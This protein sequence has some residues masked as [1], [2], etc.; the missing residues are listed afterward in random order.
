MRFGARDLIYTYDIYQEIINKVKL[1]YPNT[2]QRELE[3]VKDSLWLVL[4]G[5]LGHN[6]ERSESEFIPNVGKTQ[7][8]FEEEL[9]KCHTEKGFDKTIVPATPEACLMRIADKIS[10][11][12]SDL[13]DGLKEGFITGLNEEYRKELEKIGITPKEIEQYLKVKNYDSLGKRIRDIFTKDLIK[14]STKKRIAMSEEVGKVMHNLRR[15]NNRQIVDYVLMKEDF[16]IYIGAVNTLIDTY[17]DIVLEGETEGKYDN[18]PYLPF[19]NYVSSISKSDYEFTQKL[20]ERAIKQSNLEEKQVDK[21]EK[22]AI[23][24]GAK[25]LATLSDSEFSELIENAGLA[26][27]AQAQRLHIKYKDID[28]RQEAGLDSNW[29]QISKEQDKDLGEEK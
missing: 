27:K 15:I 14:N 21:K 25:Y 16:P 22:M 2:S 18:T 19:V 12:A 13:I 11:T 6:G 1:F 4:D 5:I 10:Y 9:V 23:A 8:D 20:V 17:R 7:E 24:I 28:L 3:K 26:T 29:M